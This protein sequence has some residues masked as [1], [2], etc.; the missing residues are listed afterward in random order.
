ML[1]DQFLWLLKNNIHKH[2][3]S[4][5]LHTRAQTMNKS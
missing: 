3:V 1:V 2:Y 4:K 5:I